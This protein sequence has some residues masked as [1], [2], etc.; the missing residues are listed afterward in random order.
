MS[1]LIFWSD[2]AFGMIFRFKNLV[3]VFPVAFF[4]SVNI[5]AIFRSR[6]KVALGSTQQLEGAQT[7]QNEA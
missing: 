1:E 2:Y 6:N 5:H 3:S 4:R 7:W